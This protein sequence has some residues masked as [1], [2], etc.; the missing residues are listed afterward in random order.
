MGEE[1]EDQLG[2]LLPG[3]SFL[4]ALADWGTSSCLSPALWPTAG[5]WAFSQ[6]TVT[7]LVPGRVKATCWF[8]VVRQR[9]GPQAT[10]K[11]AFAVTTLEEGP[12]QPAPF[13]SYCLLG[14][15]DLG[16]P[17]GQELL[18]LLGQGPLLE[19]W[20]LKWSTGSS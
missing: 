19:G 18:E 12:V 5:T 15:E 4:P 13:H 6:L 10:W 2:S 20:G 1:K 14:I 8:L 11:D 16:T 17:E 3:S 7:C 9:L